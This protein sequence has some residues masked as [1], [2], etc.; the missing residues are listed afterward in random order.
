MGATLKLGRKSCESCQPETSSSACISVALLITANRP[1]I[2][3]YVTVQGSKAL[4]A[5]RNSPGQLERFCERFGSLFQMNLT[6][7]GRVWKTPQRGNPIIAQGIALGK[8]KPTNQKPERL[9]HNDA[10]AHL[11]GSVIDEP[12]Q[13]SLPALIGYPGRCPGLG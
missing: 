13:G 8:G 1:H 10:E 5:T 4:N 11:P 12:F 2:R 7:C 6:P 3:N 9:P